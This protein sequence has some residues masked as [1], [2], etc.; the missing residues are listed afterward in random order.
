[1]TTFPRRSVLLAAGVAVALVAGS[2]AAMAV[3]THPTGSSHSK[4][5][6]FAKGKKGATLRFAYV[7]ADALNPVDL[8]AHFTVTSLTARQIKS[9]TDETTGLKVDKLIGKTLT[10]TLATDSWNQTVSGVNTSYCDVTYTHKRFAVGHGVKYSIN[11]NMTCKDTLAGSCT[12]A[13]WLT[14][15]T[16]PTASVATDLGYKFNAVSDEAAVAAPSTD[17]TLHFV[18]TRVG[19]RN[20]AQKKTM[21]TTLTYLPPVG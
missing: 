6:K 19:V 4:A 5:G 11:V 14:T 15:T 10:T 12:G 18:K 3:P 9:V 8:C 20:K 2:T 13:A 17:T 21:V 7:N 1:M 16:A